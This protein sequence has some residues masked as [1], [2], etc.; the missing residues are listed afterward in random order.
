MMFDI[1]NIRPLLEED[2]SI[3][4]D[5]DKIHFDNVKTLKEADEHSLVW[6]KLEGESLLAQIEATKAKIIVCGNKTEIPDKYQK[7]KCFIISESPKLQFSKIVNELFNKIINPVIHKTAVIDAE[8]V[9]GEGT[10]IGANT[11]IGKCKIGSG[12]IIN[13][14]CHIDDNTEIGDRVVIGSSTVI[15]G[16]GFG[17]SRDIDGKLVLFPHVGGV[18]IKDDVEIG[19]NTSI[20]RGSLG[21]TI[22]SSGVK[23]DNLVHVAHNVFIGKNSLIIANTVLG[24]SAI[25]GENTWI[26]PSVCLKNGVTIGDNVTVGMGAI[27]TKNIPDGETWVGNPAMPLEQFMKQRKNG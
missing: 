14:N 9:I 23:I 19:S 11:V 6:C 21:N 10:S 18:V 12:C 5:N 24:G 3:V 25:I 27:V 20:D 15:G 17:Y 1:N 4:G 26:A 16:T 8:A 2:T 22:I 13:C 7:Q